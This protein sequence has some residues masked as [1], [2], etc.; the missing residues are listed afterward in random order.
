MSKIIPK[1]AIFPHWKIRVTM[2][3]L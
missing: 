1:M 3:K 2:Y